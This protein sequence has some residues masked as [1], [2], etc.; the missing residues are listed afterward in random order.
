MVSLTESLKDITVMSEF[1][2]EQLG[3]QYCHLLRHN[4][5]RRTEF[6]LWKVGTGWHDWRHLT[7]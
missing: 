2:V 5:T 6:C 7:S 4:C 3:K 1:F